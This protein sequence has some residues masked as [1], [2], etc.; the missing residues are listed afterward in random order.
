MLH[1]RATTFFNILNNGHTCGHHNSL[2]E[3]EHADTPHPPRQLAFYKISIQN[4]IIGLQNN[5]LVSYLQFLFGVEV[6]TFRAHTFARTWP[7]AAEAAEMVAVV[8]EE[9][10]EE[11]VAAAHRQSDAVAVARQFAAADGAAAAVAAAVPG[12]GADDASY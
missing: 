2:P 1:D 6:P 5:F 8:A 12:G 11:V 4:K 7:A 9:V 3:L 10:V